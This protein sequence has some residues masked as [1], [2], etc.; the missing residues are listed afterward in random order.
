MKSNSIVPRI[1]LREVTYFTNLYLYI[2][3]RTHAYTFSMRNY[4]HGR[5]VGTTDRDGASMG[6]DSYPQLSSRSRPASGGSR[7]N[8]PYHA[9]VD[10]RGQ[11]PLSTSSTRHAPVGLSDQPILSSSRLTRTGDFLSGT[12]VLLDVRR[13]PHQPWGSGS[14]EG[15]RALDDDDSHAYAAA[16]NIR[17]LPRAW[18]LQEVDT[19]SSSSRPLYPADDRA[20][21]D[22][23]SNTP[24]RDSPRRKDSGTSNPLRRAL[25]V[26]KTSSVRLKSEPASKFVKSSGS[27]VFVEEGEFD[28][29]ELYAGV[30][31]D[32]YEYLTKV[33]SRGKNWGMRGLKREVDQVMIYVVEKGRKVW[34]GFKN[35]GDKVGKK[36][37]KEKGGEVVEEDKEALLER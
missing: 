24:H 12:G 27:N 32:D 26:A 17:P 6:L 33:W 34:R 28:D 37:G 14:L 25:G 15:S 16:E 23:R 7:S 10:L 21:T 5:R 3:L 9:A 31:K 4:H 20:D 22:S 18:P 2:L 30:N 13:R 35:V 19:R 29:G 11:S 8:R 1:F 36:D